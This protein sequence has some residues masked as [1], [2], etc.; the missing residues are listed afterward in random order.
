MWGKCNNSALVVV[1]GWVRL[2]VSE[3][4]DTLSFSRK[5]AMSLQ[6]GKILTRMLH[7]SQRSCNSSLQLWWLEKHLWMQNSLNHKEDELQQQKIMLGS[8]PVSQ[9][10][11]SE[12]TN[13]RSSAVYEMPKPVCLVPITM[14][15]QKSLRSHFSP[16]VGCEH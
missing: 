10:Q 15:W 13:P 9:E 14:S 11:E 12:A 16:H 4:T 6:G 7:W 3:I 5:T 8:M 1:A 2:S